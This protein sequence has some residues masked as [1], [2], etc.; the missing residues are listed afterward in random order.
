RP[1]GIL[2]LPN[3]LEEKAME[4]LRRSWA[5]AHGGENQFKV[6]V[7][8]QGL[9]FVKIAAT[10]NEGQMLETRAYQREEIC[11]IFGVPSHMVVQ[12]KGFGKSNVEQSSIEF[13]SYCL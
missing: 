4:N 5:E 11:A 10:P 3:K 7:L 1:A 2:K 9:D 12:S 6:A 8:E 13:V